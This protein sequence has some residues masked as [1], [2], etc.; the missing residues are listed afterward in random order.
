[1]PDLTA[2]PGLC[3]QDRHQVS[4]RAHDLGPHLDIQEPGLGLS[5]VQSRAAIITVKFDGKLD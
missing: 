1:M 2:E 3:P 4:G 5:S